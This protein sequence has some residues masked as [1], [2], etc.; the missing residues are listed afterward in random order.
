MS[1]R[2]KRRG[3][4]GHPLKAPVLYVVSISA[5]YLLFSDPSKRFDMLFIY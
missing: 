1:K 2:K 5:I 4:W 3:I